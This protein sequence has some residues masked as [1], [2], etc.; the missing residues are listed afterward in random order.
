MVT[1]SLVVAALTL[2][3]CQGKRDSSATPGSGSAPPAD[4]AVAEAPSDADDEP[5]LA[6]DAESVKPVEPE[7]P[8]PGKVIAELGA[9][10]AWQAVVDRAQLL[11]RRNQHGIVYGVIGPAV[12]V[13]PPPPPPGA[14]PIDAGMRG[15]KPLDAG[16]VPSTDYVWLVDDTDGNGSLGIRVQLG[17]FAAAAGERVA[18][19]GAWILDDDKRWIWKVDSLDK[20]PPGPPAD[21]K[22]PPPAFP[23]HEIASGNLPQGARTITVGRDHDAVYFQIVGPTPVREGDGWQVADELGDTTY[24][25]M[26]LPGERS[27]YGGQDMRGPD[28]RWQLRRGH[29]YWV[30]IGKIRRHGPDKPA[31]LHARTAPIRVM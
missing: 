5:Q 26:T 29:T 7:P 2:L 25:L 22:D 9:I 8:D 23:S 18:L 19:G 10:P 12:L 11:A 17:T 21:L 31:T 4:D 1:R 20:L 14:P 13:D 28:E 30:R 6:V 27:S 16:L 24:A 3:A 15:G